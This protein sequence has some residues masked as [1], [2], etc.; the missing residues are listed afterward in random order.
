MNPFRRFQTTVILAL[1]TAAISS[2]SAIE[3]KLDAT[4]T[5]WRC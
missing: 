2:T 4:K 5:R 3:V 1:M